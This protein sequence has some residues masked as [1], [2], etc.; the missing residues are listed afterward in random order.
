MA[1]EFCFVLLFA[2]LRIE[3]KALCMASKLP[4][5][6]I[7]SPQLRV[8]RSRE[9]VRPKLYLRPINLAAISELVEETL[10]AKATD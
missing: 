9:V 1:E 5:S 6:C 10:Q 3:P 8:L 2:V 4:L 7:P